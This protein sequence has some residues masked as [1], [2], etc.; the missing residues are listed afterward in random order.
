M[1]SFQLLNNPDSFSLDQSRIS[2]IL[3]SVS[4][5]IHIPQ[6]GILNIAFLSDDEIQVL[7]NQYRSIDT[8]T[9]V[10]SFHYYEEFSD[11]E[12]DDVV[13]EIILSES[14]ILSQSLDH[15]H[16]AIT[17]CEILIVHGIL[18]IL[19]YDHETDKDYEKMWQVEKIVR[20]KLNLTI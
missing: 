10:L 4:E 8:S 2:D 3:F 20:E 9:D 12:D 11:V 13:G 6:N 1:F 16:T 15:W 5:E 14:R 7:N 18:H 19:G 17:E